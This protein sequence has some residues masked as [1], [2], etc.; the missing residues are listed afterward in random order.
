MGL[1]TK[2]D[3]LITAGLISADW[4]TVLLVEALIIDSLYW[5]RAQ[6]QE[7]DGWGLK[8]LL[9]QATSCVDLGLSYPKKCTESSP[10]IKFEKMRNTL[11][12]V[13]G[14]E[15]APSVF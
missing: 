15:K 4:I 9:S 13:P 7:L 3:V 2:A 5:L 12:P 8:L 6:A 11:G 1:Y 14:P 10:W